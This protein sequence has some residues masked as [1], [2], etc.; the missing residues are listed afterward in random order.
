[1]KP[2]SNDYRSNILLNVL[3]FSSRQVEEKCP[4]E[5]TTSSFM[6]SLL[7]PRNFISSVEKYEMDLN[8]RN[9]RNDHID[10]F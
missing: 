1:M 6:G 9:F 3:S 2:Q 4:I 8:N 5:G 7:S 10:R